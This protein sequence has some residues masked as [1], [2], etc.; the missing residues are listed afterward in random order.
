MVSSAEHDAQIEQRLALKEALARDNASVIEKRVAADNECADGE[1]RLC[2]S[3]R[4]SLAFSENTA[5]GVEARLAILSPPTPVAPEA[6]QF[7]TVAAALGYDKEHVKALAVLL[8][9]FFTTLFLEF[10]TIVSFGFAFSPKRQPKP[11]TASVTSKGSEQTNFPELSDA[12]LIEL[13]AGFA[14]ELPEPNGSKPEGGAT[15]LTLPKRPKPGAPKSSKRRLTR[16]EVLTDLMVRNATGRS[17]G[18]QDEAAKH[19]G[20]SPSRFSEWSKDW[21]A[22]GAIPKRRMVGRC[23]MIET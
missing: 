13:W 9:P 22:E 21:E 3:A 5:K 12:E 23:K 11:V 6:E 2:K 14:T 15:V 8:A 10:G 1:G 16:D 4:A 19:Y 17:F 18:S 20:I 7:A